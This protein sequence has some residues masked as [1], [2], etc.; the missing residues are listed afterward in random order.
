MDV[1]T[2]NSEAAMRSAVP[3]FEPHPLLRGGHLQTVFGRYLPSGVVRLFSTYHELELDDGDRLVVLESIPK[4]WQTGDPAALLVHG[5][6]GSARAPYVVRVAERLL[7]LGVRVVRLNLRG[8]GSG[9]GLAR[10]IY[11]AGRSEDVRV[12]TEWLARRA[13]GSP[14]ALVGFSLGGNLVLKLAA[15]ATEIPLE[16]LDCVLAANPPLD[17]AACC[18]HIRRRENRLYDQNF[19]RLLHT[20]VKRLHARFPDL[21]PVAL[22][23]ARTLYDFDDQYTAPRNGYANAQDYYERCSAGPGIAR[24]RSPGLVI[25]ALDDP[26]IPADPFRRVEFPQRL[27]LELIS[28]GGHLGYISRNSWC[29]SRRWLDSRLT[30]WLAVH[31]DGIVRRGTEVHRDDRRTPGERQGGPDAHVRPQLQ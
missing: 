16:G 23:N 28:S 1:A 25:H 12:A 9:F 27:A 7:R 6:A 30:A 22:S 31:W 2:G 14:V 29:G 21:G 4:D 5:L 17:L 3:Q 8:A 19:V 24:I 20:E 11:H 10:G 18:E 15:E 13:P 26:F